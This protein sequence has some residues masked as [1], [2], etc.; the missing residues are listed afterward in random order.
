MP[1][2]ES[3]SVWVVLWIVVVIAFSA[4]VQGTLGLGFPMVATPLIAL[5]TD[6]KS[7]VILV[8]LPCVATVVANIVKGGPLRPVLAEFWMMPF[9]ALAGAVVGTSFFIAFPAFPFSVLLAT[10][11]LVYLNLDRLGKTDWPLIRRHQAL[12]GVLFGLAAGFTEGTANA[13]APPLIVYYLALG[14]SP[15]ALV[16]ALNICFFAGKTTQFATLASSGGVSLAQWLITLPF[17]A[18]ATG[19]VLYGIRI[20]SRVSVATYR[21]WLRLMLFAVA[22][23]LLGQY[24]YGKWVA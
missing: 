15:I 11:L 21:R 7:A 10:V 1:G 8:L 20:R 16:Q 18:V 14:L 23:L 4:L 13:A 17:A 19:G 6:M 22:L 9:Y 12:F 24:A 5:A 3:F 2:F